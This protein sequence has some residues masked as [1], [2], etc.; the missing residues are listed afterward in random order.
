MPIQTQ[1]SELELVCKRILD[2]QYKRILDQ[3]YPKH[4]QEADLSDVYFLAVDVP[5][6]TYRR[7]YPSR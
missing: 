6:E 4:A 3:Q 1:R 2:Q 5:I 7:Q